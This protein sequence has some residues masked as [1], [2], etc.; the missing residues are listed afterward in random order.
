MRCD[1]IIL[2]VMVKL[3]LRQNKLVQR[4]VQKEK[5]VTQLQAELDRLNC[6]I[7]NY[8]RDAVSYGE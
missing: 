2:G 8:A 7:S 1:H 3:I 6:Q 4:L 5:E